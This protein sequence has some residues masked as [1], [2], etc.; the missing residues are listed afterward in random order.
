[1]KSE[2]L[3][4]DKN[5]FLFFWLNGWRGCKG[6]LGRQPTSPFQ[7]GQLLLVLGGLKIPTGQHGQTI[8]VVGL[9]SPLIRENKEK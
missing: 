2:G 9:A 3:W 6:Q 8:F 4:S 1:M 5:E 7:N